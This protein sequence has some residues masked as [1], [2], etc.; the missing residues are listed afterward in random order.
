MNF[1]E[2]ITK[3]KV[4]L[5]AILGWVIAQ[6]LKVI[7]ILLTEKKFDISRFVGSGGMPSSHSA[8]VS[9][10][11]TAVGFV[12]GFGSTLFAIAFVLSFIVMYDAAGV[13]KAAGEQ[14]KVIN[15]LQEML[16]GEVPVYLKELLGHT[17]LEVIVGCLLGIA[18]GLLM[19]L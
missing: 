14:A 9:A 18:I 8:F 11:T 5:A 19:F 2:E 13:R 10:M 15:D 4:L 16:H 17:L 7:Y 3:N 1:W 6:A 12:E